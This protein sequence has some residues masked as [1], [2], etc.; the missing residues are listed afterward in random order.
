MLAFAL[1][2]SL[3]A[4]PWFVRTECTAASD[5]T[6]HARLKEARAQAEKMKTSGELDVRACGFWLD[7]TITEMEMALSDEGPSLLK[8][9]EKQLAALESFGE[10]HDS[11]TRFKDL[12]LEAKLR[13]IR[14]R[15]MQGRRTDAVTEAKEAQR[16]LKER[17][18]VKKGTPTY[19]YAEAVANLAVT[20]ASWPVRAAL[21]LIGLEGDDKRGNEALKILLSKKSV[22]RSEVMIVARSFALEDDHLLGRP[23]RYSEALHAA[24]PSN[25]QIA[26]DHAMDLA[27]CGRCREVP[28][29][30]APMKPKLPTLSR[31]V[32]EK[33]SKALGACDAP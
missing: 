10:S 12:I 30:L 31:K 7:P 33:I 23:L 13:R 25:P 26:F 15:L 24:Y 9:M 28:A 8:V 5:L 32:R 20:H 27:D 29:T 4:T 14:L 6:Y 16:L 19:F 3:P 17:R 21:K 18:R 22:Y 11:T 1:A 2:A